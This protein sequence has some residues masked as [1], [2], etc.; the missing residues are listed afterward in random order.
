MHL[1][2]S[3][4]LVQAFEQAEPDYEEL[5]DEIKAEIQDKGWE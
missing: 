3:Y 4:E 2:K 1:K 5:L